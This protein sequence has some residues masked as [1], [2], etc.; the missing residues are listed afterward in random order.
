MPRGISSVGSE[1]RICIPRVR[2]SSPLFSTIL[3]ILVFRIFFCP[4]R[5]VVKTPRIHYIIE[6]NVYYIMVSLKIAVR[7]FLNGLLF[8]TGRLPG[9]LT[10]EEGMKMKS[11]TRNNY[12]E[13]IEFEIQ[14]VVSKNV[15][16]CVAQSGYTAEELSYRTN[17]SVA[18][19]NRLKAGQN[20]SFHSLSALA[21]ALGKDWR[22][23][24]A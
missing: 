6:R 3:K 24:F 15:K 13:F 4:V 8:I 12:S 5:L 14:D 20:L 16:R 9:G 23:F 7:N 18:T 22:V 10:Q 11:C 21:D 2:G 17:L 1:H 19:I